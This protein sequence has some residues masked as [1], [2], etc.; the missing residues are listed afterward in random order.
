MDGAFYIRDFNFNAGPWSDLG[1]A[2]TI[3]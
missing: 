3:A 1:D 2:N